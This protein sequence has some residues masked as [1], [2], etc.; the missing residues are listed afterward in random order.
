MPL[1][2]TVRPEESMNALMPGLVPRR[3]RLLQYTTTPVVDS[4]SW[5]RI[6]RFAQPSFAG[7]PERYAAHAQDGAELTDMLALLKPARIDSEHVVD[8][9]TWYA[10]SRDVRA[11]V[12][13]GFAHDQVKVELCRRRVF[14]P[15][16]RVNVGTFG[17][18]ISV[19]ICHRSCRSGK[20]RHL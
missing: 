1:R 8:I 18:R 19:L 14:P 13:M 4:E 15:G 20:G 9:V 12:R 16:R 11:N 2:C 3:M 10:H 5:D 17:I 7:L 6:A